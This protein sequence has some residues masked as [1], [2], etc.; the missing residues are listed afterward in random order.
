MIYL[1]NAATTKPYDDI[2]NN[3]LQFTSNHYYN[4]SSVYVNAFEVKKQLQQK[5]AEFAALLGAKREEIVFTSSATEANNLFLQGVVTSNKKDEFVFG[6]GEHASVFEVAKALKQKG[7]VVHFAKLLENGQVDETHLISLVNENTRLVSVMHVSN[8]TGAINDVKTLTQKIKQKNSSTLVHC[9]GVQAFGKIKV[10]VQRLGVDAYVV[11]G[12]KIHAVKGIGALFLKAGVN[13]TAQM[14]GGGQEDNLR[15]G[16]ENVFGII[17]LVESAKRMVE[18]LEQNHQKVTQLND[19]FV[20]EL[21]KNSEVVIHSAKTASPYIIS[22]SVLGVKSE[23]LVHM[24]A[25]EGV[26][27]STG[28]SCS[29]NSKVAGNRTL[30]AMGKTKTE[31]LGSLRVSFSEYNTVEEVTTA[32]KTISNTIKKLKDKLK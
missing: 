29:S 9:D 11:S 8:E 5:K 16:T 1:D 17:T 25:K 7:V 13:V 14:L 22:F 2:V 3:A 27:V 18:N 23:I 21:T 32:V 19:L 12:H 30:E 26:L 31:V 10:N 15:S 28:S 24:L 4:P 20:T 6:A